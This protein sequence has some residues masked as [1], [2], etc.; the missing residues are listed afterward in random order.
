MHELQ[1]GILQLAVNPFLT[2]V[3]DDNL[4]TFE[5]RAYT[6]YACLPLLH[7]QSRCARLLKCH[8][9]QTKTSRIKTI[10]S[11]ARRRRWTLSRT[12]PH[13]LKRQDPPRLRRYIWFLRY[14][15]WLCQA[16]EEEYVDPGNVART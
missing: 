1:S 11:K 9:A 15:S 4:C 14:V 5:A 3:V 2:A 7:R 16:N 13:R 6:L 8:L 12:V 10:T